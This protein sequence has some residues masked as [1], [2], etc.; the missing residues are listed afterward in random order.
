VKEDQRT[1]STEF[2]NGE[3]SAVGTAEPGHRKV[4]PAL[5]A[6]VAPGNPRRYNRA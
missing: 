3:L 2:A 4:R 5:S 6:L 1:A